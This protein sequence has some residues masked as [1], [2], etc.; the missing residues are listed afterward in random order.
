[1]KTLNKYT[2]ILLAGLVTP[3]CLLT[4]FA[5]PSQAQDV[6]LTVENSSGYRGSHNNLVEISLDNPNDT[7]RGVQMDICDVD[8]YL[9][10]AGCEITERT[11]MF[12]CVVN[13]LV[14]GC[15]KVI[16][17]SLSGYTIEVGTGAILKIMYDVSGE[18]PGG[19]CRNLNPENAKVVYE[20][21]QSL[22]VLSLP[23]EFCFK[24][25][26]SANDCGV[27]SWCYYDKNCVNGA[28][29]STERC[30]NDELYCNGEVMC[31]ER[32]A[33]CIDKGTP[34]QEDDGIYC[35]G[36]EGCDEEN[37]R[38]LY[39]EYPCIYPY[40]CDEENDI[41]VPMPRIT[42][43]SPNSCFQ[44]R[45][46]PLPYFLSIKASDTHFNSSS[47]IT[48]NPLGVVLALP[49]IVEDE[50]NISVLLLMMPL[51]LSGLH[52]GY[53]EFTINTEPDESV[54]YYINVELLPF[55][56]DEQKIMK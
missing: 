8:N 12:Y 25:C 40:V 5:S 15:C 16:L 54:N 52:P 13:E 45:W 2:M 56:L 4:I 10:Y 3:M 28:C 27:E 47:S 48:F 24:D 19:E 23:G 20:D 18:A 38:C 51:W 35:N 32:N 17:V 55:P 34:C 43:V 14:D 1:M 11:T 50:E 42:E 41:C 7:I 49:P 39:P 9:T 29:E 37:D 26:S 21:T 44:S 31:D 30:P 33:R 22:D 46:L 6:T 36:K 53:V